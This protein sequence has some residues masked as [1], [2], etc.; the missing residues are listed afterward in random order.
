MNHKTLIAVCLT[1]LLVAGTLAI[2]QA[3]KTAPVAPAGDSR[4]DKVIEQN[5]KIL[6]QQDQILKKLEDLNTGISALRRRS[7]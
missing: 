6:D 2:G 1:A 4:L 5:Q 3:T 7:S